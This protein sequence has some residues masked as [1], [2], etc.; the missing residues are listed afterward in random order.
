MAVSFICVSCCH[1][2]SSIIL[3]D[4]LKIVSDCCHTDFLPLCEFC[5]KHAADINDPNGI[6]ACNKCRDKY[7][8]YKLK[9]QQQSKKNTSFIFD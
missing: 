7:E 3:E 9:L 4:E 1:P 8:Q 6:L 5:G 2:C